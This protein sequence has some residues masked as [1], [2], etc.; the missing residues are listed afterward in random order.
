MLDG[1]IL[2]SGSWI[3]AFHR[4][5]LWIDLVVQDGDITGL[6]ALLS[7]ESRCV[8]HCRGLWLNP[9]V[10]VRDS[11]GLVAIPSCEL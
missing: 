10:R 1:L 8:S 6:V 2:P 9:K 7:C 4:R 5:G 3:G 11:T